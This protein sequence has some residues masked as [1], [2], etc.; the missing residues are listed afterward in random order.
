MLHDGE[1]AAAA[2][3]SAPTSCARRSS[4]RA[5]TSSSAIRAASSCPSTTSWA[6]TPSCATSSSGTSRARAHAADGYARATGKVGVCLGTSGPGR[7]EPRH[8]HRHGACSTPSR[9]SRSP[10]TSPRALLGKDAFQEIDI[11]GIT[12]PM[13]KHNYLVRDADDLPRVFAEAFHIARTGRPGPVHIDIT[14]DALQQETQAPP[15]DRGRGDRRACRASGRTSRA[16]PGSSARRARRSPQ[17]RRADDPRRPRR[18]PSP[19]PGTTCVAL[20]REDAD[21]RRP[22]AARRSARSTR[23]IPLSYGY[24]GMHG[25]KHVNRAIQ[26]ADLLIAIGMRFDD[27]VTGNVPHLRAV[28]PDRPRR[29]RPGRDRQE[30]RRRGADRGRRGA[31]A[32][33]RCCRWSSRGPGRPR[34]L[35][36]R[37]W[38]EWR[39]ESEAA[40]LA[41]VGRLARRPAVRRLRDRADRRAHRPRRDAG[42]RRRPE[43]DVDGA[44]RGLPT[45]ELAHQ[46]GRPRDDGLRAARRDGRRARPARQGDLGDHRRRRLPDDHRRS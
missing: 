37:S 6:T 12:L 7:H 16:I 28:C 34:R 40:Q 21:P 2:R 24:M 30:R 35:L 33:T 27:R 11:N 41:R 8:R 31:R 5:S 1:A 42:R 3:G 29:H 14:K 23:R 4:A 43:P 18:P 39:R 38:P 17:A 45:A 19:R 15:P 44:L 46:L 32:A 13:T 9:W 10:A 36:R 25:W 26:S 22:H 20:R